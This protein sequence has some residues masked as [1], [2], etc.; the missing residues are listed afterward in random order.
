MV[1]YYAPVAGTPIEEGL[2]KRGGAMQEFSEV[3]AVASRNRL[4]QIIATNTAIGAWRRAK[5]SSSPSRLVLGWGWAGE[6]AT[7]NFREFLFHALW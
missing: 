3:E 5:C 4:H 6:L 7:A 2:G 1:G